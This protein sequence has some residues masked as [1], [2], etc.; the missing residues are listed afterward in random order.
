MKNPYKELA[1]LKIS[2]KTLGK[3]WKTVDIWK[4]YQKSVDFW[5]SYGSWGMSGEKPG[6]G[7]ALF[8]T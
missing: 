4:I 7:M 5:N 6:L 3:E 8:F 1:S 2:L